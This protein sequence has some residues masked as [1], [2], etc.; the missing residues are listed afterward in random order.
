MIRTLFFIL[1]I[2]LAYGPQAQGSIEIYA[3]GQRYAS[4]Q[5]YLQSEKPVH[6]KP[7]SDNTRQKLYQLSIENGMVGVLQDF[8]LTMDK[9]VP[10][11]ARTITTNQLQEAIEQEVTS[12]KGPK[13]LI[14]EQGKVRIMTLATSD[15]RK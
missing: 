11:M 7:L 14:S 3:K 12:S 8:Y 6:P 9:P 15:T 5:A 2:I 1:T 10:V 4:L 13:L